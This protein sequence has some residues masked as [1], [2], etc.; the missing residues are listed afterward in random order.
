MQPRR[1]SSH[2]ERIS[3]PGFLPWLGGDR[4]AGRE[5]LAKFRLPG[6]NCELSQPFPEINEAVGAAGLQEPFVLI[7]SH[8]KRSMDRHRLLLW[9]ITPSWHVGILSGA[10]VITQIA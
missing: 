7:L 10:L 3:G 5:R 1:K 4:F 8:A 2:R 6:S 9:L